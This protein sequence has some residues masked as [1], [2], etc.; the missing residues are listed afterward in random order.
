[1][2]TQTIATNKLAWKGSTAL[3]RDAS[4]VA[5]AGVDHFEKGGFEIADPTEVVAS[6]QLNASAQGRGGAQGLSRA[7]HYQGASN[8]AVG[9]V[10]VPFHVKGQG[11]VRLKHENFTTAPSFSPHVRLV[12]RLQS[13]L[14]LIKF[15]NFVIV[16]AREQVGVVVPASG[17]G[18]ARV[19]G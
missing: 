9:G 10:Q 6:I 11:H 15:E 8:V 19:G 16:G 18:K 4:S 5:A 1:M 13:Q 3:N 17:P 2:R 7:F 12:C 14:K